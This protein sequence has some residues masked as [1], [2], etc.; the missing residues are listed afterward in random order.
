MAK[1]FTIQA[2]TFEE[3]WAKLISIPITPG[4]T[5]VFRLAWDTARTAERQN[6]TRHCARCDQA[7]P[8]SAFPDSEWNKRSELKRYCTDCKRAPRS[9]SLAAARA[10]W[11]ESNKQFFLPASC[12]LAARK[13]WHPEIA[14]PRQPR[15]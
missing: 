11:H 9:R 12:S 14:M 8:R 2:T 1:S 15:K 10:D 5:Q 3:F 13:R 4:P 6:P 7:K